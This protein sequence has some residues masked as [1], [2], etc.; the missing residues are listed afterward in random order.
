MY[1]R[2]DHNSLLTFSKFKRTNVLVDVEALREQLEQL[3]QLGQELASDITT[4]PV[5]EATLALAKKIRQ[6][7]VLTDQL[8][9]KVPTAP[10]PS[11][12]V[13]DPDDDHNTL[14]RETTTLFPQWSPRRFFCSDEERLTVPPHLKMKGPGR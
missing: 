9:Q 13:P 4:L 3:D 5:S 7:N 8:I 12:A 11:F 6:L 1:T 2:S 10:V 14:V